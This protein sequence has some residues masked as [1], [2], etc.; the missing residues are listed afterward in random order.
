MVFTRLRAL[1]RNNGSI[2]PMIF[3]LTIGLLG[4]TLAMMNLVHEYFA[5]SAKDANAVVA[6]NL[7]EATVDKAIW[8]LSREPN[9]RN[10]SAETN[11]PLDVGT[12]S[13]V[14]LTP[15]ENGN[16]RI[17]T[18]GYVPNATSPRRAMVRLLVELAP[19]YSK[20][21]AGAALGDQGVPVANGN[22]D[23]Y[24]SRLGPYGGS[25]VGLQGSVYT[26]S[27][28]PGS[29]YI[30]PNGHV[31]GD[32]YYP[33][34]GSPAVVENKGTISGQIIES[35]AE[36][37]FVP[38]DVPSNAVEIPPITGNR[39][40]SAGTYIIRANPAID[41]KG[42][43]SLTCLG[44]VVLYIDG[45]ANIGGNG[46]VTAGNLPRNLIIYGLSNCR[47]INISGNGALYAAVY[48]PNADIDL[49]G[50][51]SQGVV[52]GSLAGRTVSFQG[53]GTII[54]YDISLR[55]LQG[56][57]QRYKVARWVKLRTE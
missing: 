4:M 26:N 54:H 2:T 13:I 15:L 28:A 3:F 41:L 31:G 43:K 39:V 6:L 30:G 5:V 38:F 49:N 9:R 57:I 48:A 17:I 23:S 35:T 37:N 7:A 40:L 8:Y 22:T 44:P 1:C 50:A 34:G 11:V 33:P 45:D 18:E 21:F 53:N 42:N 25:N 20:P 16:L 46:I 55:E 47:A 29:I 32:V 19:V 36:T 52:F 12:Y 24:D 56:V 27:T 10:F 14:S 51:G